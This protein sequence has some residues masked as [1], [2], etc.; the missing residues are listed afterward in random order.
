MNH[1]LPIERTKKADQT[2]ITV[3]FCNMFA[4]IQGGQGFW[5][6][7]PEKKH[8]NVGFLSRTGLNPLKSQLPSHHSMLGHHRHASE[9]PFKWR[10]AG[11]PM[12]ARL[13]RNLNPPSPFINSKKKRTPSDKTFWIHA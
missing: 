3:W 2:G 5:T 12:M 6:P 13:K 10:F 1:W 11:R 4:Q 8:K 7:P 9:T